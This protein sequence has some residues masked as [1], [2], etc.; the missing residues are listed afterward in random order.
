MAQVD[1][2]IREKRCA[3]GV[4]IKTKFPGNGEQ[5]KAKPGTRRYDRA[6]RRAERGATEARHELACL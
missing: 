6:I 1:W 3:N 4:C 5:K 2:F